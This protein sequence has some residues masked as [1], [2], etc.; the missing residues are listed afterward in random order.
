MA[1]QHY[2]FALEGLA[3]LDAEFR[4]LGGRLLVKVGE[5]VDVLAQPAPGAPSWPC[6]R[7]RRPATAGPMRDLAVVAGAASQGV[8]WREWPQ[9]GVVGA[10]RTERW[11]RHLGSLDASAAAVLAGAALC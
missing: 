9:F 2:R 3:D 8:A 6:T 4:R 1:A 10:R 7:T 5:A 11:Q